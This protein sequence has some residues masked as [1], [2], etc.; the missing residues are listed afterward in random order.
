MLCCCLLSFKKEMSYVNLL[1]SCVIKRNA[2]G[3]LRQKF[4]RFCDD[5]F[6]LFFNKKKMEKKLIL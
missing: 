5:F 3:S 1:F 6:N 2:Y 4:I